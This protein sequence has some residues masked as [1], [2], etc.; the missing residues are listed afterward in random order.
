MYLYPCSGF[1][2]LWEVLTE[3][4]HQLSDIHGQFIKMLMELSK[5]ILEYNSSQKD[6]LK[7]NV[8]V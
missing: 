5:E 4:S 7:S 1:A 8:R 3:M 2:P 6:K